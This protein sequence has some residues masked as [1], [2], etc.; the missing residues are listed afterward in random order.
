MVA[1]GG[2][3]FD[4][5]VL[6]RIRRIPGVRDA[7]PL[8]E[9][10]AVVAGPEGRRAVLLV[11]GNPRF[12]QL[13]GPLIRQFKSAAIAR[14]RGV[15]LPAPIA[16]AIG[17][18]SFGDQVN[19]IT[20]AGTTHALLGVR[21]DENDIGTLVRSPVMIAPLAYAQEL[22][23][24]GQPVTRIFV[25][26][27]GGQ[28]AQVRSALE[29]IADDRLAVR[30]ADG[31]VRVFEQAAMPTSQSTA[32]F[33]VFATLVG[34]LF[35][36]S[37][38]L[39]TVPQRRRFIA[40]LRMAGHPPS[41]IIQ[42]VLF[43]ALLAGAAGVVAGL[44]LGDFLSRELFGSVPG[45]LAFAFPVG[46]QR[47]VDLQSV[48]LAAGAGFLAAVVAVLVP[49]R[50]IFS[51]QP[52]GASGAAAQGGSDEENRLWPVLLG[53]AGLIAAGVVVAL[54]PEALIPWLAAMGF[55]AT[56]L[57][58][59]LPTLLELVSR[60]IGWLG[61]HLRG[62]VPFLA[63]AE[64]G[65]REARPRTLALAAT[66][67]I[68]VF[69]SVAVGGANGDLQRGLDASASDI[70][71]N[72]SV[73]ASFPGRPNAFATTAFRVSPAM[74]AQVNRVPGVRGTREY[75]G[76]FLDMRERRVWVLAPSPDARA[77]I[78]PSQLAEGDLRLATERV[79]EGGWVVLSQ[80]V[81]EE[82]G[83]A[84]GDW[85]DLPTP[86]PITLRV[87]A[88]STNLG[89][90]PGAIVMNGND[91]RRGWDGDAPT[92]LHID[93]D[94]RAD[95]AVVRA[96]VEADLR[97]SVPL[98]VETMA[99]REQ[100]HYA[101]SREGLS[102]LRQIALLVLGAAVLAMATAMA[103]VLWQRRTSLAALKVNGIREGTLW[104]ALLLE[105]A[106]ILGTGCLAGAVMGL[107]G[108]VILSHSLEAVT[109]FPVFY[110][111]GALTALRILAGVMLVA[112]VVL[113]IAGW[114]VVRV[115]PATRPAD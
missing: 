81:A 22:T 26:P 68:A 51:R 97:G 13:G 35:A 65:S 37:A 3:T 18:G 92:A 80:A 1:R 69:A 70:D 14:Q 113:S 31:E 54:A 100:R 8:L 112:L 48:A 108:Q 39:L 106:A 114:M 9:T 7:A 32:L 76:A 75:R 90:P 79:R 105:C 104:R 107:A 60:A 56:A 38:V 72:A 99:Q 77:P 30:L 103:G 28:D 61:K 89:W 88:L 93:L 62:P 25:E 6:S 101:A 55:L 36:L 19:V 23:G 21:L 34:F 64:L 53:A 17:V 12:A 115:R 10:R 85:V 84:P 43:E 44:V 52:A 49:L 66:G 82:Q 111:A 67:A 58:C 63:L 98:T 33:A 15:A 4:A 20:G 45:Y 40:V 86:A 42:Q 109:G 87:A 83:V 41:V 16:R 95:P 11:G 91:F 5:R 47:V 46:A 57:V 24:L 102:R 94:A 59:F 73:W 74:I 27:R 29:R 96:R 2:T 110:T 78:P 71:S 50:E